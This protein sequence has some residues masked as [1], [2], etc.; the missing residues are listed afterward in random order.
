MPSAALLTSGFVATA[1]TGLIDTK[2]AAAPAAPAS[3]STQS[4]PAKATPQS[5]LN[6][7]ERARELA[8][9]R[10]AASEA[11][12]QQAMLRRQNERAERRETT[13]LRSMLK[14]DKLL[15]YVWIFCFFFFFEITAVNH[16]THF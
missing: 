2:G 13:L 15:Q 5:T 3:K 6:A 9:Q 10:A 12:L 14:K 4:K 11:K 8:N 16:P 7:D 1:I